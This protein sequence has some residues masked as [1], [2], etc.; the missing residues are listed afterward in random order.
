MTSTAQIPSTPLL[1]ISPRPVAVIDIGATSIRMAIA[2]IHPDGEVRT[3]DTLVQPVDL[4]REAFAIRRLSRKSIERAAAILK[5]YQRVLREY[6]ITSNENVRVVATTAVR[7]ALNRL[8]F[9]DRAYIVTGLTVETID[10][11]EVSRITYMGIAPQLRSDPELADGRSIVAEVGGGNT[12]VL[13]I[14][15]GNVLHSQSYRLGSLRLL[16]LLDQARVL[17][18]R[19]RGFLE[20]HIRRTLDN[21]VDDVQPDPTN[22]MVAFG[23]DIRFAAHRLLDDWDGVSLAPLATDRLAEFTDEVLKL[24]E[25]TIVR[26]YGASFIEAETLGPALLGYT[27]LAQAFQQPS[28]FVCDTNLRDGLLHDMAVGGS[29]TAEFRNQ[30]VRSALGLGRRFDFDEAHARNVA[31]LSRKLFD[32]LKP[33]HKLD[34]RHEVILHVAA[35]L[36]EI[37]LMINV[38]SNHKHALYVIRNSEIFGLSKSELLQVGLLA[39]YHRR[40][41]PQPSHEGYGALGR[42]ERVVVAK[43]ASI[44]RLAIALDDTR[45]GRIREIEC[46]RESRQLVINVPGVDD[47]SLEQVA[48]RQNAGLFRDVFGMPVL[49]RAGR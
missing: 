24:D 15:S 33:E 32:Q 27:M 17:P 18:S 44:L 11:A 23:G 13:V 7:E 10:E 41:Y 34:Y 42:E 46:T 43:L 31:E 9:T 37:G 22:R 29:W 47:V 39:R 12:E 3:L 20:S 6:G 19:R 2:E 5:Q 26:R 28:L 35:L 49:L 8:A 4:G 38:R 25:D 48:M 36:H 1:P 21:M 16:Q 14:R 30:I 45:S 40:A